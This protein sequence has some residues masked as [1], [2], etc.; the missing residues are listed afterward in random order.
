MDE[1]KLHT[2]EFQLEGIGGNMRCKLLQKRSTGKTTE[3]SK[4]LRHIAIEKYIFSELDKYI[5]KISLK[6]IKLVIPEILFILVL[7]SFNFYFKI[8]RLPHQY[9]LPTKIK[10]LTPKQRL[11]WNCNPPMPPLPR[12]HWNSCC[13]RDALFRSSHQR[14]FI[15]K[16]LLRNFAIFTGKDPFWS[17]FLIEFF[18]NRLSG[19]Q[20]Y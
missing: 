20:L 16:T 11:F 8:M 3:C 5:L 12:L 2:W 17:L 1:K 9:N 18:F 10:F 15:K 14:C 19:L 13:S 6:Y 7:C 4:H